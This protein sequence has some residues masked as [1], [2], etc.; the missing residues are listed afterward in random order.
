MA[1]G[2]QRG[3]PREVDLEIHSWNTLLLLHVHSLDPHASLNTEHVYLHIGLRSCP[4]SELLSAALLHHSVE[5]PL[6][7]A[8]LLGGNR[9]ASCGTY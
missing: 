3:H 9:Q 1:V 4:E 8:L 5:L 7:V 6:G 2:L